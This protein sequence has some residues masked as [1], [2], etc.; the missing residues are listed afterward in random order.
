MDAQKDPGIAIAYVKLLNSHVEFGAIDGTH[1]YN[2]RLLALDRF[3][4]QDGEGFDLHA[5][6]DVM[7]GIEKPVFKFTCSFIARYT[8]KN[9]EGMQWK[10]FSS[11]VA[12][13]HIIPYLREYVS[14]ITNRLP[15]PILMLDPINTHAM[16]ADYEKRKKLAEE[17]T[18][19]PVNNGGLTFPPQ[20][21]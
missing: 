9:P 1:Q 7:H 18:A 14:N 10:D 13:A 8:R 12:L 17:A 11:A 6:F 21:P 5:A 19:H 15:T 2:L 20:A 4:S 16:I 3:E